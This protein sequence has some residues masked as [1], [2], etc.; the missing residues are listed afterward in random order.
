MYI[1]Y[2]TV[3]CLLYVL[4]LG[5]IAMIFMHYAV[6]NKG[7]KGTFGVILNLLVYFG[8]IETLLILIHHL[9]KHVLQYYEL[10]I[11][12]ETSI[13]AKFSTYKKDKSHVYSQNL[14]V[15]I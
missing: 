9:W 1:L 15:A 12:I 5:G 13:K 11:N 4:L 8:F 6:L 7:T 2:T 10:I 14:L 3:L